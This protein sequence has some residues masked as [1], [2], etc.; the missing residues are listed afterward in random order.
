[1]GDWVVAF[2]IGLIAM[3]TATM[4]N[5]K[6]LMKTLHEKPSSRLYPAMSI[7]LLEL[8]IIMKRVT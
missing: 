5:R 1:M 4:S 3:M 7:K 6:D 8:R 2:K